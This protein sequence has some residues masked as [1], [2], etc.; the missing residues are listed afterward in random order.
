[1]PGQEKVNKSSSK[2]YGHESFLKI[3]FISVTM[4]LTQVL[5]IDL[6]SGSASFSYVK[7]IIE[8]TTK[9]RERPHSAIE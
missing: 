3:I 8:G 2:P 9:M 7:K 4:S 6:I 5:L 1:M